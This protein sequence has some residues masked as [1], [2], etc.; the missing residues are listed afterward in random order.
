MVKGKACAHTQIDVLGGQNL[1][2]LHLLLQGNLASDFNPPLPTTS[3][4]SLSP[5]YYP[6]LSVS[7]GDDETDNE[8]GI[9]KL[10]FL[11]HYYIMQV[12]SDLSADPF[13]FFLP[14]FIIIYVICSFHH[15][16]LIALIMVR[17]SKRTN[18]L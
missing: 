15:S 11:L 12:L 18:I 3:H 16:W 5:F 13:T 6:A 17:Q 8:T 1:L 9:D 4:T 2:L 10:I 14:F 7:A